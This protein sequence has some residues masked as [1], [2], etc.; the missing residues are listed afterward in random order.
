MC[1][2]HR[3]SFAYLAAPIL[4][5]IA[6]NASAAEPEWKVGLAQVKVTPEQPVLMAGYAART[7]P[8]EKVATD[9]YVKA[10]VIE[11]KQGHRGALVTSDL[12]GF[13]ASVAEPI[14]ERIQKSTG[15]ARAEILLNSSHTHTGPQVS[16]KAV[17]NDDP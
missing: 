16:L 11:D 15:L 4:V 12:I 7:K 10:L 2:F 1:S 3:R 9:L 13:P 8:F 5:V 14:C 17:A 6:A